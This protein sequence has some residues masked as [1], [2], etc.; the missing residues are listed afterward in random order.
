MNNDQF[1][2]LIV[3][4]KSSGIRYFINNGI[5]MSTVEFQAVSGLDIVNVLNTK[6]VVNVYEATGNP[7]DDGYLSDPG[8]QNAIGALNDEEAFRWSCK[9]GRLE[10]AKWLINKFPDINIHAGDEY[11]FNSWK[12]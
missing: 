2:D 9:Y 4:S 6:N 8:S 3:G 11:A 7:D 12:L 5:D 10:T 1:P